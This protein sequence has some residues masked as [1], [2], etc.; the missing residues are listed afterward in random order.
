MTER[1]PFGN[2]AVKNDWDIV[3][4][5]GN[6]RERLNRKVYMPEHYCGNSVAGLSGVIALIPFGARPGHRVVENAHMP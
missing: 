3:T 1:L 2:V 5:S 4:D 6:R